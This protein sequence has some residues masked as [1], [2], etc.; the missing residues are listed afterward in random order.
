MRPNRPTQVLL[1]IV[2]GLF[3]A[4][5]G[6]AGLRRAFGRERQFRAQAELGQ[7][8]VHAIEDCRAQSGFYPASLADLVPKYLPTVPGLPDKAQH[9][10]RGWDYQ[11][12]T[13]GVV[14]TYSLRYYM[15]R[16]GIEHRPPH[17]LGN[18][19]GSR[20]IILSNE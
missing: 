15:G 5:G 19:E 20:K 14:I 9:K 11:T 2:S 18:N 12:E 3:L 7:P 1:A 8:I 13:N 16:G 6:L 10:F 17:W 4:F